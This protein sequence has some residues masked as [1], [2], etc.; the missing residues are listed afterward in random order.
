MKINFLNLLVIATLVVTMSAC[1]SKKKDE[2]KKEELTEMQKLVAD[3]AE[4][5]LTANLDHLTDGDKQA[6]VKLIEVAQ[7]MDDLFWKDAIGDKEAFLNSI[8]DEDALKYALIN[9][10]PWDRL[11]GNKSFIEAYGE[12]PLGANY[13]PSDIAK[14]EFNAFDDPNKMSWYTLIRRDDAGKLKCVWYHEE[15]AQEIEKAAQLLEEAAELVSDKEFQTYLRLRATALRTDDY[16]TSDLA[17]MDMKNNKIDFVVGPIESY[18]DAFMGVK[19]AHSGQILIKDLEWSKNIEHFNEVLPQL[20]AGLPVAPEYKT[21]S[22][23]NSGDMNVYNAIYYGGDC[24]SGSKNIAINLP[25]DPR[26]HATKGSRK[27]QLKNSMEAKFN[28][29]LLPIAE[30]LIDETQLKHVKFEDA[31]FQNVMFHEVAHGL[32]VKYTINSKKSV[33][34]ALEEYYSP[35]E[36]AKADIAGLYMVTQ[37]YEMGEFPE[38]D[39]MDNYVTFMAGIFR[40]VRFG[41]AS[42]HGKANM[43]EFYYLKERGAFVKNKETGKYS[44]NFEKMKAAVAEMVNDIIVIQGDGNLEAAKKWVDTQSNIGEELQK[45]LDKIAEAGIPKDIVFKQGLEVLGLKK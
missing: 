15:Y 8:E 39:L 35:V 13:Y 7:I 32:G 38:K 29:I 14:E 22:A 9:Y 23:T 2:S 25:N 19:A 41:V 20:Q 36:E 34:E 33:R 27:L 1:N 21:E 11:N 10:G 5:E 3:Y 24:N 26:V 6:I 12:K 17:W 43:M 45:D 30:L 44:V 4:V 28:T 16:L 31:F 18:E 40:S 37:L 42:S